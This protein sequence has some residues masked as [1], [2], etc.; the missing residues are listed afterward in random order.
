MSESSKRIQKIRDNAEWLSYYDCLISEY[1][2]T[3][4]LSTRYPVWEIVRDAVN[5]VIRDLE[6]RAVLSELG[7]EW[8]NPTNTV[9]PVTR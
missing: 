7:M 5:D 8:M 1:R 3:A 2:T 4:S 6:R 9:R